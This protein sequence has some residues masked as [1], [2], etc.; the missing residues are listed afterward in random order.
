MLYSQ[1]TDNS[2]WRVNPDGFGIVIGPIKPN[3]LQS[4]F[5]DQVYFQG[6]DDT[7]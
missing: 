7:A 2:L 5:G 1:G 4:F 3:P 6:T